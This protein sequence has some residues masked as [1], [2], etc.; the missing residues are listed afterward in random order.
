M[1]QVVFELYSEEQIVFKAE[2]L[3]VLEQTT[4]WVLFRYAHV[5]ADALNIAK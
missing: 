1:L 2:F 3:F 5:S 4:L